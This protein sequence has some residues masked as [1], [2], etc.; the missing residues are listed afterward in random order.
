MHGARDRGAGVQGLACLPQCGSLAQC[1][2]WASVNCAEHVPVV[3]E[4]Q[5]PQDSF[6]WELRPCCQ[7]LVVVGRDV[8]CPAVYLTLREHL[9][10]H[11]E[12][13]GTAHLTQQSQ[14]PA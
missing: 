5:E 2:S 10:A 12:L 7:E 14:K 4:P 6:N 9:R 1:G 8:H 13:L 3:T 11:S